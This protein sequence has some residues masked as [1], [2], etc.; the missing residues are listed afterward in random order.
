M[1]A[2]DREREQAEQTV[3]HRHQKAFGDRRDRADELVLRDLVDHVDQVHAFG[4]V[5]VALVHGVDAQEAGQAV[6]LRRPADAHRHRR[7]L[8]P[9]DHR[10]LRPVG[11]GTPQVVDVAGRDPGEALVARVAEDMVLAVQ[12]DPRR[13]PGHLA[14][15]R[16]HPG[17]PSRVGRRVD[18]RE[19]PT[20][21]PVPAVDHLGRLA[22]LAD[23]PRDLGA[24]VARDLG[25][26]ALHQRL[27]GLVQG[28]VAEPRQRPRHEV[29]GAA[30]VQGLELHRL[31]RLDEGGDL[32]DCPN[33]FGLKCHDHLP[34][35]PDT[36]GS[37]SL[38]VGIALRVQAHLALD[39]APTRRD[40]HL[41]LQSGAPRRWRTHFLASKT[42]NKP[43]VDRSADLRFRLSPDLKR[44]AEEA[45]ARADLSLSEWMRR[46]VRDGARRSRGRNS[47]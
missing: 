43:A 3:E 18:A 4:A 45:A 34:M 39:K 17:Q 25:Q 20:L 1:E 22:V 14:E 9:L 16:V 8:R 24:R 35:I 32:L 37:G 11:P 6:R 5:A 47:E 33:A 19:G 42:T 13:E 30:P 10:A 36:P 41:L 46:L 40:G 28:A 7:R 2:D 27:R 38:C 44:E 12:H 26:V 31:V 23:Q 29:V 15:V 21:V